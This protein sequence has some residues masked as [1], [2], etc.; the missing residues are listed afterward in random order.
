[1]AIDLR[2][3][4]DLSK[5]EPGRLPDV[6]YARSVVH[7]NGL[8]PILEAAEAD[9]DRQEDA[10]V[11]QTKAPRGIRHTGT[12]VTETWGYRMASVLRSLYLRDRKLRDLD[13]ARRSANQDAIKGLR[14]IVRERDKAVTEAQERWGR[15]AIARKATKPPTF[16]QL[17]EMARD[18]SRGG[19]QPG[20]RAREA[21]GT[22][23]ARSLWRVAP[24]GHRP[25]GPGG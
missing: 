18:G 9:V 3:L 6:T 20:P 10:V 1:M 17:G 12:D 8:I 5:G 19:P 23:R 7:A 14:E 21:S 16:D 24:A 22:G 25:R 2:S 11:E 4:L 13:R 15:E